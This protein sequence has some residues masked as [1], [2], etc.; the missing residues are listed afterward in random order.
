MNAPSIR[1]ALIMAA[2]RGNRMRPLT[3]IIPKPM[4]PYKNDTLIGNSLSML[5]NCVSFIHVTVGYKRAMLSQYLMERGVDTVMNTEGHNNAWWIGNT[6][7]RYVDEPVLVLT[8]DNITELDITFLREEYHRAGSPACMLVPVIP[9]PMI[10]GDYIDHEDGWV[11]GVQRL[12]PK[13]IYCSGIQ[14]I[15]PCKV[16]S[17]VGETD[18]FYTVWNSLISMKQLRVSKVYPKPWFSIDTLEQLANFGNH[19]NGMPGGDVLPVPAVQ[20]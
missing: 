10:E 19:L 8:T 13:E 17:S 12:E 9:I 11:T 14:V 4:L 3:D 6:L 2:G 18:D 7:M 15:N 1:H 20:V 16:A 5:L